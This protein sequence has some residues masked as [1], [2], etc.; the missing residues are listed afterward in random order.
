MNTTEIDNSF[1]LLHI[2]PTTEAR[3]HILQQL[4][5]YWHGEI[6]PEDAIPSTQLD[7]LQIPLTLKWW[8][9][10]AGKRTTIMRGQNIFLQPD[11]LEY[12][13]GRL[14]FHVENEGEYF[15]STLPS[16]EDPPVFGRFDGENQWVPEGIHLSEHL[17]NTCLL[18]AMF[19][20]AP[21]GASAAELPADRLEELVKLIPAIPI[22]GWR[23]SGGTGFHSRNGAFM[24]VAT[25]D[26]SGEIV[27]SVWVAAKEREALH[28]VQPLIDDHWEN[29]EL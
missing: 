27:H 15:W 8:Y 29:V 13:Q 28:V 21:Y 19:C 6:L 4:V 23:W 2:Y 3:L 1:A 26:S 9:E 16:G 5:L 20:H 11:E 7:N 18:E 14:V 10:W 22:K 25:D 24:L 12:N 17:I